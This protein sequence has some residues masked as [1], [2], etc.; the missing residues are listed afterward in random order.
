MSIQEA[1]RNYSDEI[2]LVNRRYQR[3]LVWTVDEKAY[4]IDSTLKGLPIPL[5]LLAR[6]DDDRLEIIDGL[7][8]L[9]AIFSFIENRFDINGKYFDVNQFAR[10]KQMGESGIF[11]FI[12]DAKELLSPEECADLL[13]YQLAITIYPTA[14]EKETTDIFGRI[15]SGGKQLSPQEKRQAGVTDGFADVVRRLSSEIRGDSSQDIL[16][17]SEMPQISIDSSR[18]NIGYGLTAEE[19]FWCEHGVLWKSQLRDSEDEEIVADLI[20]S[21]VKDTPIPISRELY[22]SIYDIDSD[23]SKEINKLLSI[24]GIDRII[25]E[26]KVTF[27]IVKKIFE[28]QNTT[29]KGV[30]NPGSRNPVKGSFFAIFMAVFHLVVK[31]EKSPAQEDDIVKSLT[32]LQAKMTYTARTA[33]TEDRVNNVNLTIGLIQPYF[34]KKDPPVLRHGS[35][36]A[37]DFENSIRR[38]KV[39]T[40]RYECKQGFYDLSSTR[41]INESL[42]S[43]LIH[44]MCGIANCGPDADGFIFIGV[45]DKQKDSERILEL[46]G[47]TAEIINNRYVVGIERELVLQGLSMDNYVD[48]IIISIRNSDLSEPTKSQILANIDLIEYKTKNI[49]RIRI[50]K[51]S[52]LTFIGND[53]YIREGSNTMM[54]EGPKLVA[55]SKL[56]E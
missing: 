17:L 1:Y 31:E 52:N 46:D 27:S 11:E 45:A 48:K 39:E 47:I 19:I 8:R 50:P 37:L 41:E 29:V 53:S 30:V 13:D 7:Q 40:N 23:D 32:N 35:G 56:F 43:E 16:E 26:I 5:I 2:F 6:T 54:L 36:L 15:N 22:N 3:K 51:Q 21:I 49:V 24:Y 10:A 12:T 20:A 44:T 18:E 4:L 55:I 33:K 42:Y 25:H 9:N 28:C 38:S 14:D 34:V